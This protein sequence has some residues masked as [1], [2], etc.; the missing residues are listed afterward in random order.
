MAGRA[1][2]SKRGFTLVELLVVIAIIGVLV[3][4]LLPAVQSAREASRRTKCLNNLKQFAIAMHNFEGVNGR[5]PSAGWYEW[6]NAIPAAKPPNMP[7]DQW[8]QNGCIRTW[9]NNTKNSYS[10]G[11]V[12]SAQQPTGTPWSAPPNQGSGWPFQLLPYIEQ[13]GS[14]NQGAAD[15]RNTAVAVLVCSSRRSPSVRFTG[16][17]VANTTSAAG[18]RPLCYA[19]PYFGPVVGSPQ[20]KKDDPN[21]FLGII[22]PSEPNGLTITG[23]SPGVTMGD[24]PVRMAMVTDGT[25]NTLL[26]G[27]KWLRPDQ[28]LTGSWGDDHNLISSLDPDGIRLGDVSPV[29]DTRNSPSTGNLVG[30]ADNNPCCDWWR[31]PPNRMPSPRYGSYFGGA[32]PGGMSAAF[33][34]GS[35]R[36]ISWQ[37]PQ[38]VFAAIGNKGDGATVTLE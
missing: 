33:A 36:T 31:D 30:P 28:Y 12:D 17:S 24:M 19:A 15:I 9:D 1:N 10:S 11:P 20:Q 27:E 25:S 14:F 18:G 16:G 13:S 23:R 32:H 4:L 6:C 35:V 3:A 34:D 22:V 37:I 2:F 21:T 26:L 38:Q 29:K 7:A 5:F 8:G